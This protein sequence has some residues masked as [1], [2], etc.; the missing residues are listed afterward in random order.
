MQNKAHVTLSHNYTE[1]IYE[2]TFKATFE[3][4][5]PTWCIKSIVFII[6]FEVKLGYCAYELWV[7]DFCR[8]PRYVTIHTHAR[9]AY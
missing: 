1:N 4:D 9:P 5:L 3:T 6:N 7:C 8:L 2:L